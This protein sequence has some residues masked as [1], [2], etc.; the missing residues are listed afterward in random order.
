M[1]GSPGRRHLRR[2][3]AVWCVLV[4]AVAALP[5]VLTATADPAAAVPNLTWTQT[6]AT[7]D[8]PVLGF[9][10]MA[11]DPT[12]GTVVYFGGS[13]QDTAYDTTWT[14]NGATWTQEVPATSPPGRYSASMAYDPSIGKIVL[15]GGSNGSCDGCL[16]NDT[17]AW[18]GTTWTELHPATS[19]PARLGASM[20]FD[21]SLG[22]LVLFGG[23]P[24]TG[25]YFA[26]TWT[27][28][29]TTWTELT[30]TTSPSGRWYSSMAF[31]PSVGQTVLFGGCETESIADLFGCN[32]FFGDTWTF[33]GTTWT[34]RSPTT[35]PAARFAA[36][37]AFDPLTGDTLLFGGRNSTS[38]SLADTWTWDGN[39]WTELSPSASP[40]KRYGASMAFDQDNATMVLVGGNFDSGTAYPWV[41][42][43]AAPLV[44]LWSEASP[45]TSPS[46]RVQA[47]MAGDASH[48]RTV[49]FG[50]QDASDDVLGDTWIWDGTTWTQVTPATSPP[51]RYGAAIVYDPTNATVLLFGGTDTGGNALGDLWSWDGTTWT[52]LFPS[53]GPDPRS[54]AVMTFDQVSGQVVLFGGVATGTYDDDTWTFDGTAW[55]LLTTAT[56][57]PPR[58]SA[59]MA[60]DP[61]AGNIVLFGGTGAAGTPLGDTWTLTGSTW[62][63]FP[64]TPSNH[65][66]FRTGATMVYDPVGGQVVLFG[67]TAPDGYTMNDTWAW[68]G[69]A[70][71][72]LFPADMPTFR[73]GAAM[74]FDPATYSV[75]LF[76][77]ENITISASAFLDDT[78]V[79]SLFPAPTV[80]SVSPDTG[81]VEGG[82][83]VTVW[84]TGFAVGTGMR[85]AA[86]ATAG[87]VGA[88]AAS[89]AAPRVAPSVVRRALEV[90]VTI[91]GVPCTP[92]VVVSP[93]ELTC[94]TGPS[95]EGPADVVVTVEGMRSTGG[96]G[97]FTHVR[98]PAPTF[99]G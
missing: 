3:N 67:G 81:S 34:E 73:T 62:T 78:W 90:T 22:Q 18:D 84:G 24:L 42:A 66:E 14:G 71:T 50:G 32:S 63:E 48:S 5:V 92:V 26:D 8:Y 46:A 86:G 91:G 99:T 61:G 2:T 1:I 52:E 72:E 37:M 77:G 65:P 80:T 64:N 9:A 85:P 89:T 56:A 79:F 36:S 88:T 15:F 12:D 98:V 68:S 13:D 49:L 96:T 93:T 97:R 55:T 82:T 33:D 95:A 74:T 4:L 87:A 38:G 57:P 10:S 69:T 40:Q 19:P 31:D 21:S 20:V 43:P 59:T 39:A 23:N 54:G 76:G 16:F 75:L 29:G 28:D 94:I 35:A 83:Q 51:A 30:P 27:F 45:P 47:A 6:A 25:S 53:G 70:W 17:W 11:Y 60:F 41:W 7:R 44:N 58:A